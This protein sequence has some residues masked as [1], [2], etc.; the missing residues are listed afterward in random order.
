METR[1]N[2]IE[3][4]GLAF[5]YRESGEPKL[6]MTQSRGPLLGVLGNCRGYR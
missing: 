6:F 1:V 4:N 2:Q 3:L 5:Q